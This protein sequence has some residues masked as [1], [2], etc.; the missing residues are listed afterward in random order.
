[1]RLSENEHFSKKK[2]FFTEVPWIGAMGLSPVHH[3]Y[4]PLTASHIFQF[5]ELQMY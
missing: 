5:H 1:M 2:F 4:L 3:Q